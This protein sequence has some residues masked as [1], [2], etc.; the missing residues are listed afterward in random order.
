LIKKRKT[1]TLFRSL[2]SNSEHIDRLITRYLTGEA[3]S[4]EIH[5]LWLWMDQSDVNRKYFDGIRFV[6][7]K[8]KASEH[9]VR[10]DTDSAWNR[11]NSRIQ[12]TTQAT[13]DR[14]SEKT[15][16]EEFILP[17]KSIQSLAIPV[18]LRVV[19]SV[20]IVLGLSL[21]VYHLYKPAK[22]RSQLVVAS[23]PVNKLKK[24]ILNDSSK[25]T[26]NKQARI[27]YSSEF[28]TSNRELTLS[29][30]AFFDVK[31]SEKL[32]FVIKT[33]NTFIKDIGTS[34]NIKANPGDDLVEVYVE[35]GT[36]SFFTDND[37]G[38]VVNEGETGV[39]S[40]RKRAF[41]KYRP[42]NKNAI[43]YQ[44]GVLSF[45]NETLDKVAAKVSEYYGTSV[46]VATDE[47]KDCC[48]TVT[49][50][51]EDISS[52]LSVI[53]ETLGLKIIKEGN[54]YRLEG[55]GCSNNE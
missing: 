21:M 45:T 37:K 14:E 33:E 15:K 55:S 20:I 36:V 18:W 6:H 41:S 34:F 16:P 40:K 38:I 10:V 25:V 19:A 48:I 5:E 3:S 9:I 24:V 12:K 26:L 11:V 7:D 27:T 17:N 47:I 4:D 22:Y 50:D 31:H 49:F 35:T 29:G 30:E 2:D 53:S 46:S 13:D 28:G 39:F 54:G 43:A 32:P 1:V 44:T 8:A 23:A 52:V 42:E 51:N